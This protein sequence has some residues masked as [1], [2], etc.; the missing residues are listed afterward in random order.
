MNPN[1]GHISAVEC[2]KCKTPTP[3][4]VWY[5]LNNE[6]AK[7]RNKCIWCNAKLESMYLIVEP[8]YGIDC[9]SFL[10]NAPYKNPVLGKYN[11][12]KT[13]DQDLNH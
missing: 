4:F 13:I 5:E 8:D 7:D 2:Y 12:S 3:V 10:S 11:Y 6:S 1:K 9:S